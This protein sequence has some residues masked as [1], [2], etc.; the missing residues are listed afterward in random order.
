MMIAKANLFGQQSV[1]R[2]TDPQKTAAKHLSIQSLFD[3]K[4]LLCTVVSL[5]V[6]CNNPLQVIAPVACFFE[7]ASIR[8]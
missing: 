7:F 4:N 5:A 3:L 1:C 8:K 2:A 6:A